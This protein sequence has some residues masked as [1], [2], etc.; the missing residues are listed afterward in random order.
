[1]NNLFLLEKKILSNQEL[2]IIRDTILSKEDYVKSLGPDVYGGTSEN[3]LSGRHTIFNWLNE[4][5]IGN[6]LIPKFRSIRGAYLE[7]K[8]HC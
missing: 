1:M 2:E 4:K 3:S 7:N 8:A 5:E 6:I